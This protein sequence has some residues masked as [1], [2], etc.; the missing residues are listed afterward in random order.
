[1]ATG[2]FF[3]PLFDP[4]QALLGLSHHFSPLSHWPENSNKAIDKDVS[5]GT[6]LRSILSLEVTINLNNCISFL[7][8]LHLFCLC[9]AI[10]ELIGSDSQDCCNVKL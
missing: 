10:L 4:V 6:K 8:I 5:K 7:V 3:S 9:F 1:M 2:S